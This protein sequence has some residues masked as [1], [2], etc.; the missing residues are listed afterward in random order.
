[1]KKELK[2]L[3]LL[4][5]SKVALINIQDSLILTYKVNLNA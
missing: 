4:H 5:Q 3:L 1:M 2:Y